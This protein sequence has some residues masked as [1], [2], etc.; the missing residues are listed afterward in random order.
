MN[1]PSKDYGPT[2]NGMLYKLDMIKAI[3]N[4]IANAGTVGYKREI[5]EAVNFKSVLNETALKDQQSGP[6]SR[7]DNKF[8][9]AIE[10]NASFLVEGPEGPI[11]TRLGDFK[12][13]EKGNL[14]N[15]LGQELIIIE[16]TDK[17]ISL[18]KSEKIKINQNGEIFV[19][20]ERFGRIAMQILD[21][22]PVK[23]HQGFVEGSNVNIMNEMASLSLIFRSFESSQQVLGMEASVDKELIEKYG[24]NV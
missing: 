18:A 22:N 9:L 7:T 5:P 3:T 19:G 16:K 17:D 11:T 1:Y 14:A 6:I 13:N 12:L 20:S 21:S 8:D 10:G 4:N 24:R 2:V 15:G 23:V